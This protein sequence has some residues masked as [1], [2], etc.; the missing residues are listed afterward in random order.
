MELY[1]AG[2]QPPPSVL[3]P[4]QL[5]RIETA[6]G[7]LRLHTASAPSP[8]NARHTPPATQAYRDGERFAEAERGG[9]AAAA[10]CAA[11]AAA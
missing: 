4:P 1:A 8:P 2:L 7:L 10:E 6:S 11:A 3:L 9:L 5:E